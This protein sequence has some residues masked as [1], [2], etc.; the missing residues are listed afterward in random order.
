MIRRLIVLG[1]A[2][3]A[4]TVVVGWWG[5]LLVSVVWGVVADRV[6]KPARTAALAAV[7]AWLVL[8]LSAAMR[9]PVWTLSETLAGIFG[10]PG[11]IL[12][13][14]T[15]VFPGMLAF[16]AAALIGEATRVRGR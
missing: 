9:G 15:V 10:M 14:T 3:A 4:L 7:V 2:M 1:S 5:V 13:V 11:V 12:L 6:T 8:L 16:A